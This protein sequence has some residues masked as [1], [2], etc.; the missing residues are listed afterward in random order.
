MIVFRSRPALCPGA[1]FCP[2]VSPAPRPRRLY[3]RRNGIVYALGPFSP[4]DETGRR[5]TN[6]AQ[7]HWPFSLLPH[8]IGFVRSPLSVSIYQAHAER[9][10]SVRSRVFGQ[11]RAFRGAM[12]SKSQS[13][14]ASKGSFVGQ[15]EQYRRSRTR[16][17][18][19]AHVSG[20]TPS[21]GLLVRCIRSSLTEIQVLRVIHF[22][23]SIEVSRRTHNLSPMHA[24][25]TRLCRVPLASTRMG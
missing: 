19:T 7:P 11:R 8:G 1:S 12:R 16:R 10:D 2:L 20:T 15:R 9:S 5:M 17:R 22:A 14:R 25:A 3:T 23:V 6:D 21:R 24:S 18:V 13:R 4:E